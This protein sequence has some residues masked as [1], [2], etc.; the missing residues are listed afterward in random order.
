MCQRVVTLYGRELETVGEL[1]TLISE[2]DLVLEEPV[3]YSGDIPHD[4]CLC[5]I[6]LE[7]TFYRLNWKYW[8]NEYGDLRL[9]EPH[10]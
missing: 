1:L 5:P 9:L 10:G 2:N 3:Q 7:A 6:D 8:E 4:V